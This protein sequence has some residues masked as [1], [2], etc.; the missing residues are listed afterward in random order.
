MKKDTGMRIGY[1]SLYM[2]R[3]YDGSNPGTDMVVCRTHGDFRCFVCISTIFR[4]SHQLA[5]MLQA[6]FRYGGLC[7]LFRCVFPIMIM[8]AED[9][10]NTKADSGR[11]RS[12]NGLSD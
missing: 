9:K 4:Y 5:E 10:S 6:Q 8:E 7:L 1:R 12:E 2:V 11:R 3:G